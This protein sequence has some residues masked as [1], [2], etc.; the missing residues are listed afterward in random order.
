MK[1]NDNFILRDIYGKKLLMPIRRN[2]VGDAPIVLNEVAAEIWL[3]AGCSVNQDE[4]LSKISKTYN[5]NKGSSEEQAVR[6][7]IDQLLEMK[8]IYE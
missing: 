2:G 4:L 1:K 8:L 3:R 7:F 5:L 6:I